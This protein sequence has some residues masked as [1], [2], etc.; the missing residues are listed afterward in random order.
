MTA[1]KKERASRDVF[2]HKA[3]HGLGF[4]VLRREFSGTNDVVS[5]TAKKLHPAAEVPAD[6][7]IWSPSATRWDTLL[8]SSA[9]DLMRDPASLCRSFE[10]A[11][12]PK[13]TALMLHIKLQSTSSEPL[14]VF[15]ERARQFALG[16]LVG[17]HELPTII[18]QHHP[19]LTAYPH[20]GRPH[21]HLCVLA[22][23]LDL[24]GWG[25]T[26]MLANDAAHAPLAQAWRSLSG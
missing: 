4:G 14:H 20:A 8:P 19:G 22:R 25:A 2:M 17:E 9:S 18:V 5:F 10:A 1:V 23:R 11:A 12:V 3:I 21:V 26:T 6:G 7:A 15:W 24:H 13:Q 16:D